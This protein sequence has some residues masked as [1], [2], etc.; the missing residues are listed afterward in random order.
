MTAL[1]DRLGRIL[2]RAHLAR[3]RAFG[4]TV[5]FSHRG[6]SPVTLYAELPDD[7]R[8]L[9]AAHGG[10]HLTEERVLRLDVPTG[11]AGFAYPTGGA[12]PVTPGDTV[13]HRGRTYYVREALRIRAFGHVYTLHGVERK[14]LASGTGKRG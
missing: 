11:Q 12:E 13:V 6:G 10:E 7:A 5:L 2:A 1:A 4:T 9:D 3:A 14:R 8:A